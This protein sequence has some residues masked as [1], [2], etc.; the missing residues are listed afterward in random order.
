MKSAVI[1]VVVALSALVSAMPI[2]RPDVLPTYYQTWGTS[3][4]ADLFTGSELEFSPIPA[5][6]APLPS[7]DTLSKPL[8]TTWGPGE[9]E[10]FMGSEFSLIAS[11]YPGYTPTGDYEVSPTQGA[12]SDTGYSTDAEQTT[13]AA[14]SAPS[15][16]TTVYVYKCPQPTV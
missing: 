4:L 15:S 13:A 3:E 2:A 6:P 12:S 10:S 1:A 5:N 9:F 8:Y 14:S 7:L 11:F 16:T